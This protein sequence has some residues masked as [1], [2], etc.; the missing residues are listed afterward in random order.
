MVPT[1]RRGGAGRGETGSG[2]GA[3]GANDVTLR[4]AH[5][6][7]RA[8]DH[9][10]RPRRGPYS[11]WVGGGGCVCR[12]RR[13]RPAC[14]TTSSGVV[15]VEGGGGAWWV[16]VCGSLETDGR[17]QRRPSPAPPAHDWRVRVWWTAS[18]GVKTLRAAPIGASAPA[19][20]GGHRRVW[21][22]NGERRSA[23]ELPAEGFVERPVGRGGRVV[24]RAWLVSRPPPPQAARAVRS[25]PAA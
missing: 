14:G 1:W 8:D 20:I 24:P 5:N 2:A 3:A 23:L 4:R 7:L 10:H 19:A 13:A 15:A 22:S 25:A 6:V 9:G 12:G 21:Q 17:A 11:A 18:G 16:R